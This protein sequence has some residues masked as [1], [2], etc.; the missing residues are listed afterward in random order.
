MINIAYTVVFVN[1]LLSMSAIKQ[2]LGT[3]NCASRTESD[4]K[5]DSV[6][7]VGFAKGWVP[8]IK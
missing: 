6:E 7:A 5:P 8:F 4:E 2:V 3:L 1:H